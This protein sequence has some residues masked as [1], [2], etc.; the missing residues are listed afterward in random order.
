MEVKKIDL[1]TTQTQRYDYRPAS[2][3]DFV[4]Q[5]DTTRVVKTAI[6]SSIKSKKSLGHILLL[7]PA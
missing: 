5:E 3:G 2:F 6:T 4:G 1:S 7:G